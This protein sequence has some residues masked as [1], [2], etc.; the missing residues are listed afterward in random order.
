V[1]FK[2]EI[3][4]DLEAPTHGEPRIKNYTNKI[5]TTYDDPEKGRHCVG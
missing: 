5:G 3:E 2:R 4:L 1:I